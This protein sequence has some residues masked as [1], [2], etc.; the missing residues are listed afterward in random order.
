MERHVACKMAEPV[1]L[2]KAK[3]EFCA[4]MRNAVVHIMK[5]VFQQHLQTY[6]PFKNVKLT[7]CA[8]TICSS[9]LQSNTFVD[10]RPQQYLWF[11]VY[12]FHYMFRP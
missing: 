6:S 5:S 1:T 10:L 2:T 3:P 8:K 12:Y 11:N 9:I 7:I 4:I